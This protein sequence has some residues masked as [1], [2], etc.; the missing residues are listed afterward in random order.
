MLVNTT[1]FSFWIAMF[2]K[3]LIDE[4]LC[5]MSML[6]DE[7][8]FSLDDDSTSEEIMYGE[9]RRSF[10]DSMMRVDDQ[11]ILFISIVRGLLFDVKHTKEQYQEQL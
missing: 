11:E 4:L 1:S 10:K 5:H 7:G 2:I 3:D 6:E 8:L 9:R